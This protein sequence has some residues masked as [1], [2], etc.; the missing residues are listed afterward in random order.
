[1]KVVWILI[2]VICAASCGV[3]VYLL[4]KRK[5]VYVQ[6]QEASLR[7]KSGAASAAGDID[8]V[9]D[10]M[11]VVD[12]KLIIAKEEARLATG[13]KQL[14]AIAVGPDDRVYAAGDKCFVIL[15]KDGKVETKVDLEKA[16]N[17]LAVD[18]DAT[19]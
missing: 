14:R 5:P 7:S 12:P 16:P 4:A 6:Q 10:A 18:K 13:L 15:G 17:C 19:I 8:D 2:A 1:M 9:I 11:L 3:L